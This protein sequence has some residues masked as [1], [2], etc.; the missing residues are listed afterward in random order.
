MSA[1]TV[2]L[3]SLLQTGPLAFRALHLPDPTPAPSAS[4][5][6]WGL[7]PDNKRRDGGQPWKCLSLNPGGSSQVPLGTALSSP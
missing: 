1:C 5:A 6:A 7:L 2:S 3:L 4:P